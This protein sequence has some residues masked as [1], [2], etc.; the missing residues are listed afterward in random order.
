MKRGSALRAISTTRPFAIASDITSAKSFFFGSMFIPTERF[1]GF[2]RP[3]WTSDTWRINPIDSA[4][5]NLPTSLAEEGVPE[6]SSLNEARLGA[7]SHLNDAPLRDRIG[8]HERQILLLRLDVYSDREVL[9][10]HAADVDVRH[11]AHQP[12]RQRDVEPADLA[13]RRRRAGGELS[14]L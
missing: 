4:T 10:V 6:E 9:R 1:F 11:V 5:S 13:R 2:T 8:Y 14:E 3:M 12:D 7:S